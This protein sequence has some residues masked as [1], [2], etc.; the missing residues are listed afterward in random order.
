MSHDEKNKNPDL[1]LW[2]DPELEARVIAWVLGEV[3]DFEAAKLERLIEETP[4]LALFKKR[5]EEAHEL[6]AE[7]MRP[8]TVELRLS[9]ERRAELLARISEPTAKTEPEKPIVYRRS[10]AINWRKWVPAGAVSVAASFVLVFGVIRMGLRHSVFSSADISQS[11]EMP[12]PP[13]PAEWDGRRSG[14]EE[15]TMMELES[16][17]RPSL[18]GPTVD[19]LL[20][21][22]MEISLDAGVGGLSG[23]KNDLNRQLGQDKRAMAAAVDTSISYKTEGFVSEEVSY[24]V[25]DL[26]R[27]NANKPAAPGRS[28]GF[29]QVG[30]AAVPAPSRRERAKEADGEDVITLSPFMVSNVEEDSGYRAPGGVQASRLESRDAGEAQ[31][32]FDTVDEKKARTTG[33]SVVKEK[34]SAYINVLKTSQEPAE[35]SFTA[36]ETNALEEPVS[37]FSLHVSDVS[38]RLALAALDRGEL[39]DNSNIRAEE[40]Y[41]AFDYGD[42]APTA[43][44][45]IACRIDQAAH[46]ALQQRNFVRIAMKVPAIG[47]GAGQPLRLT[48]LL[49]TSGSME[50]EDRRESLQ[51]AVTVLAS[52]LGPDD[53][54][55]VIGFARRQRLLV[56]AMPGDQAHRLA[57]IIANTPSE[58][59]TNLE[60]ALELS[61]QLA[62][63][64]FDPDAQNRIVLI[65]DGAA[66]LGNADP[67]TL[68]GTVETIRQQGIAF[69]ACGVGTDGMNDA[70]LE[71]LTRKGDGRYYILDRPEDADENFADQLAGAFRPAAENVKVQVRFNPARVGNYRLIGFEKHRLREEDFRNDSV[72]AAELAAEEAAVA[73]YQVEVL[74]EGEGELGEVYV[75]F[76]D[77]A[78]GEMVERSWTA[79]FDPHARAFDQASPAVQLAGTAAV[80]AEMLRGGPMA[81]Q[82]QLDDLAPVVN[83]LRGHYANEANVQGLV[84]M[85]EELRRLGDTGSN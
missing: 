62:R 56:E 71:A 79:P 20:L 29:L 23:T 40:F 24:E 55:T 28:D 46:P 7:A 48:V 75:R 5:I 43:T 8:E 84:R 58:G 10:M 27:L 31:G 57:D 52:L 65:T 59:G 54:V 18:D 60:E 35:I 74:P 15:T 25:G 33:S 63:R 47:R 72:D 37:T 21:N 82:V 4:E 53:R 22:Q 14:R 32:L 76:R 81:E 3:S 80:L 50:R 2:I 6:A 83:R 36:F 73:L 16:R 42:L 41:N 85:Y 77:A 38:F 12:A 13:P 1:N 51:A 19:P 70:I 49:D 67:E 44:E 69:D 45:K 11:L 68:A 39:P 66:N 26:D 30:G 78:T 17:S 61:V 64:H 9:P 34:L